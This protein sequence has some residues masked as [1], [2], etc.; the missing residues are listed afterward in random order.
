MIC[1]GFERSIGLVF[2][3]NFLPLNQHRC[4]R[5]LLRINVTPDGQR[6]IVGQTDFGFQQWIFH[7]ITATQQQRKRSTGFGNICFWFSNVHYFGRI[8]GQV[9]LDRQDLAQ[10][11]PFLRGDQRWRL[12]GFHNDD[13]FTLWKPLMSR[14][15]DLH[16]TI[17]QVPGT[18]ET[19][20]LQVREFNFD[21][22]FSD[23]Q[24]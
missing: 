20:R 10:Q 24:R 11:K 13:G 23:V 2:K 9:C 22:S 21:F 7:R 4:L 12:C 19:A 18:F 16:L 6:C 14:T 17:W 3:D 5:N 1:G 8:C 15:Y